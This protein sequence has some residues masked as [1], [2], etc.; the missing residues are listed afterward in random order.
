MKNDWANDW[1]AANKAKGYILYTYGKNMGQGRTYPNSASWNEHI[2]NG[3]AMI[4]VHYPDF[5]RPDDDMFVQTDE[6][7]NLKCVVLSIFGDN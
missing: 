5:I 6:E 7:D 1:E 3:N 4:I 2:K